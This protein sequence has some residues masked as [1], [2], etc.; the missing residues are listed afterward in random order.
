MGRRFAPFFKEWTLLIVHY[1]ANL[2]IFDLRDGAASNVNTNWQAYAVFAA[3]RAFLWLAVASRLRRFSWLSEVLVV[4]SIFRA[5][6]LEG[7][8]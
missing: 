2:S 6:V 1:A 4:L 5:V 8:Q 3:S 7:L